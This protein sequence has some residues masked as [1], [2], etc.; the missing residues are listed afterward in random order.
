MA[1][2]A[3]RCPNH[4]G[5]FEMARMAVADGIKVMACPPHFCPAAMTPPPQTPA[6]ASPTSKEAQ[7]QENILLKLV[8]G[9]DAPIR[10]EFLSCL[11]DG[12][13]LRLNDSCYVFF[14]P[15]RAVGST[16]FGFPAP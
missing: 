1:R 9:S 12:P 10:P 2:N 7:N 14:K 3:R 16:A 15:S 13:I 5:A 11:R 6:C 8:V 4:Q